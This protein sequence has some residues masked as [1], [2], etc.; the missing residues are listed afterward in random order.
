MIRKARLLVFV[1]VAAALLAP[2]SASQKWFHIRVVEGGE[3]G[4]RVFINLP[5]DLIHDLLPMIQADS[6]GRG[7]FHIDGHE[8]INFKQIWAS[9]RT[10]EDGEYITVQDPDENVRVAKQGDH[11]IVKVVGK[12]E[13]V[14]IRIRTAVIDAMITPEGNELDLQAGLD[15]LSEEEGDLLTVQSEDENVRIWIDSNPSAE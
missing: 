3:D 7:R 12:D 10:A 14:D 11:L 4:E 9:L 8:N 1:L 5:M 13:N 6:L 2:A 15:A